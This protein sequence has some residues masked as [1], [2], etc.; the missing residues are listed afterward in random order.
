MAKVRNWL[1]PRL[2]ELP[3][4]DALVLDGECPNHPNGECLEVAKRA[5]D[6]ARTVGC[7]CEPDCTPIEWEPGRFR[8]DTYHKQP[9]RIIMVASAWEN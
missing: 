5:L 2:E 6:M 3:E 1:Y 7:S 9:C 8:V 4:L